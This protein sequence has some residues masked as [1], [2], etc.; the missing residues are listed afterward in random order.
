[1]E[2]FFG[3]APRF[4]NTLFVWMARLIPQPILQNRDLMTKFALFSLPM[5]RLIDGFV[6]SN[7]GIRV[8]VTTKSGIIHTGLLTH[9]DLE[10]AV[11]DAIAAFADQLLKIETSS[12]STSTGILPGIYFPEEVEEKGVVK[13]ELKG[14][15]RE[16]ILTSIAADAIT[17]AI[18]TSE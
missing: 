17:Y 8:D 5:V 10:K 12:S 1:M 2:T 3:T 13:P 18:T 7:N 11:G 9:R 4:W 14:L 15:F 6:G 16:E